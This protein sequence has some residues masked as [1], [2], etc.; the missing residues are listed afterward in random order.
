MPRRSRFLS[1]GSKG[2]LR[3]FTQL[4]KHLEPEQRDRLES[5]F[6]DAETLIS[7]HSSTVP[8]RLQKRYISGLVKQIAVSVQGSALGAFV[9]W[10]RLDD[11]KIAFHELQVSDDDV[12]SNPETFTTVDTFFALEGITTTKFI[13][14]RG[15]RLDGETGIWSETDVAQPNITAPETFSFE[16]Y[17]NY[18][19]GE[20]PTVQN[21]RIFGGG[22]DPQGEQSFY[23]LFEGSFY[24]DRISGGQS[25]WGYM[26]ARLREFAEVGQT[27]WDRVRFT[28]NGIHRL[29]NYFS[30]WTNAFSIDNANKT[31]FYVNQQGERFALSFYSKGGYTASFGPYGVAAPNLI[32]GVGP[33]DANR[34]TGQDADSGTFYWFDVMNARYPSRF[35]QAQL[36]S[37]DDRSV[38]HEAHSQNIARDKKTHWL[39]FQ[40]FEFN[41]P[42]DRTILG[43]EA[44]IKR[45]QIPAQNSITANLGVVRPD[46]I[47]GQ[48]LVLEINATSG[49]NANT[50][51]THIAFDSTFGRYLDLR[52]GLTSSQAGDSS[53]LSGD[54]SGEGTD[55]VVDSADARLFTGREFTVSTW[56][57]ERT[58][59]QG[60]LDNTLVDMR[61]AANT[62]RI[63]IDVQ[64]T[65][66]QIIN[67]TIS[68]QDS[69]GGILNANFNVSG[70][71]A[72]GAF[73]VFHHVVWTYSSILGGSSGQLKLYVDG[74]ERS[75]A[76]ASG[77]DKTLF[78]D[79]RRRIGIGTGAL[80]TLGDS[81]LGQAQVG[82]WNNVLQLNEIKNLFDGAGHVDYRADFDVYNSR[83]HLQ[84][85]FLFFPQTADV[86]D[87][88][89]LLIDQTGI[90]DDLDNKAIDESWPSL[91][92]FFYTTTRQYGV[93]PLASSDGIPH[94][95]HLAIGYQSYGGLADLWGGTWTP[96]QI[97]N[98]YFGLAIQAKNVSTEFFRG[99]AFIDHA[100]LTIYTDPPSDNETIFSVSAAAANAFYSERE[101]FAALF[102]VISAGEKPV[103]I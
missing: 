84:H 54:P 4:L 32:A 82:I 99:N 18:L 56:F 96:S 22:L 46:K 69:A 5:A 64:R 67:Y 62:N 7:Y 98:F 14:V 35:D 78:S 33:N 3:S 26:G 37:W 48:D 94:D 86:R 58:P 88:Q 59:T 10:E 28:V 76:I 49:G 52:A 71:N 15:V 40:D 27:P 85:Y 31:D 8:E 91:G 75:L 23:T 89:V 70:G 50:N 95:N 9:S 20:D 30:H 73:D 44:K 51:E 61:T 19:E 79:I 90:R 36:A 100:K 68:M 63:E 93:L 47:D 42:S 74:I 101:L 12:F 97:N 25:I 53:R 17:P 45:R 24:V 34:V 102:N 57:I 39:I 29:D 80:G 2:T 55:G 103:E 38:A 21:Q 72:A 66:T 11:P 43:I 1:A 6:S 81:E 60:L 77:L 13:R 16:F 87:S 65:S 41:V 92:N 83:Q